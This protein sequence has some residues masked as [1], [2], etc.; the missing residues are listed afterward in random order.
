MEKKLLMVA[1][2][3]PPSSISSGHLRPLGFAKY[4]PSFG[5]EPIIL[6]ARESA[7]PRI[8]PSSVRLIPESV[9]V[10]RAFA[11]DAQ[12]HLGIRGKYPSLLAQPDRWSSWWPAAVCR[13]LHLI[14]RHHVGVIWSTY[15][16]MTA[17]CV[18]YTLSRLTGLPWIADFRDPVASSVGR[19]DRFIV[20]TQMRWERRVL[21]RAT[22]SI[23]TAPGAMRSYA[24]RYPEINLSGRLKV[25]PNG[26]DEDVF[27]ELPSYSP[28]EGTRPLHLVHAGILY[29]SGRS[30][31]PF[32]E[33]LARLRESGHLGKHEIR[34]TLRASGSEALYRTELQRLGLDEVVSLAPMVSYREALAEQSQSD[35][36]LLFQGEE[37][38]DQIPAKLYEYLRIGRPIFA[39]VGE[40]GDTA[41]ILREAG[42]A[43][44]VP[45]DDVSKIEQ[46]FAR[47]VASLVN[48]KATQE[49]RLDIVKWSRRQG[50]VGLAQLLDEMVD[51]SDS[52]LARDHN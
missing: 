47:F 19:D 22:Y 18:A 6:S 33:A 31:I 4:L 49:R 43:E 41:A 48:G 3:I 27:A 16:I 26:F 46:G 44:V 42:G 40:G 52:N 45:L 11:M 7:Y 36:L 9:P 5:W 14:R 24:E 12:R 17:H 37:Y 2:H 39:L 25:I 1:F 15:P 29:P 10:Y 50:A 30:P 23:F 8:D 20:S 21:S 35:G 38:D 51:R 32:F 28:F 13:G 34:V